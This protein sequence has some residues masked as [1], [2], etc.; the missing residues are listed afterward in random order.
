MVK[1]YGVTLAVSMLRKLSASG[2]KGF[3]FCTL[4]L[5][6]SIQ[7]VL[8]TLK[9][10]G[11]STLEQNKLI[12]VRMNVTNNHSLAHIPLPGRI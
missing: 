1:N 5:E 8:E 12:V 11:P 10:T 6:K 4:N 2:I 7:R 3:H 9:W